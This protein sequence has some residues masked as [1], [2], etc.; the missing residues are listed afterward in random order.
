NA[1]ASVPASGEILADFIQMRDITGV[2][3]ANFLAGSRSTDIA[4]S[5]VNWIFETAPEFET[6]GFL[7]E[8]RTLCIGK[9]VVLNAYNFSPGETYR[10]QDG[11]ADST[12]TTNAAGT[13]SVEVTFQTSCII[14]D[15][16]VILDADDF[17]V[18]LPDDPVICAGDTLILSGDA[19]INSADYLWQDGSTLP[20]LA[21][22]TGGFYKLIVDL[23]GCQKADST[24]LTVTPLPTIDLGQ[25][26]VACEGDNF[27][28]DA[29]VNAESFQWQ[30]GSTDLTFTNDQPGI[31]WVEAVNGMCVERDSVAVV[32]VAPTSVNLGNDSTLCV[33][34]QLVLDAGAPG[35]T[36][37]WQDGSGSQTF[38]AVSTGQ[39]FVAIDTAGCTAT[40]TINLNF[41]D[42]PD[43]DVVDGYEACDG[44][45]LRITSMTP[46][47]AIRWN[48]GQSGM[49]FST[50]VAGMFSVSMDFGPCT[51]DKPFQVD[52]LP[53]PVVELGPDITE[54]EG[55]PVVLDA[56]MIGLWQ[57]GSTAA[58]FTTDTAGAY[59]V[60][61]TDGPC[62]VA[63][64]VNVNFL[65][66]PVFSLGDDQTTC[67]GDSLTVNVEAT[68][69]G[70][71]TW[72]DGQDGISRNFSLPGIY[73]VEMED[74]NGCTAR[75]S[76]ELT[77]QT[78]PSLALGQDTTACDDRPLILAP[79]FDS[80]TLSWPDGTTGPSFEVTF[81]GMIVA[82]LTDDRCI[83]RDTLNVTFR[84]CLDFKAYMPTAFSPNFDGIND[85]FRPG[86]NPRIEILDYRIEVFDRWG[87]LRFNSA[88]INTGWN[89]L[90]ENGEP[91]DVGVYLYFIELTYRDDRGV[92]STLISG[93]VMV[94][95]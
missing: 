91:V 55:I 93:D 74:N 51:I 33:A 95:R 40:D 48:N 68:N 57:D 58:T 31:Y 5:N 41:P 2:G 79:T 15:T 20:T 36:Y 46:A 25:D 12:F 92:G 27:T 50:S 30:D 62:A 65:A 44:E 1:T 53:P 17:S 60:T 42:L 38:T 86:L 67:E 9:D 61:V 7:G 19:G 56:G 90:Q 26:Q 24:N 29:T 34:D 88:D 76:V 22:S 13:Y 63:D 75:D 59:K 4:N 11:S 78:P 16:I 32:Y 14:R 28:L 89:G 83:V 21:A 66:A 6:I 94:I 64:S 3:G 81:P 39:Y 23:G 71:I 37:T 43:L 87:G 8:D 77:F 80:G 70:F 85:V 10:W 69:L 18:D 82:T 45:V 54:C 52:F 35:Y 73:W 84:E 47:D 72:N 49:N